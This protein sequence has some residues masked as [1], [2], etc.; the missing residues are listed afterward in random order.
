[1]LFVV[2]STSMPQNF[3]I[4]KRLTGTTCINFLFEVDFFQIKNFKTIHKTVI[5]GRNQQQSHK[6]CLNPITT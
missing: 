5:K 3:N 4:K 2:L 6:Y 1:M